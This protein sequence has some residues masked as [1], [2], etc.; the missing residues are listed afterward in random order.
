MSKSLFDDLKTIEESTVYGTQDNPVSHFSYLSPQ[1]TVSDLKGN[2][3]KSLKIINSFDGNTGLECMD[4][5]AL[6]SLSELFL[7]SWKMLRSPFEFVCLS[8][9]KEDSRVPISFVD[10]S[11]CTVETDLD[12]ALLRVTLPVLI[13]KK[14]SEWYKKNPQEF[15]FLDK[16][17]AYILSEKLKNKTLKLGFQQ[18]KKEPLFM[19]FRRHL[20]TQTSENTHCFLDNNNVECGVVTNT[21]C[22]SLDLT[23]GYQNMNFVYLTVPDEEDFFFEII[24]C[25]K[26]DL[27]SWI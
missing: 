7:K 9:K 6:L 2:V 23:D 26:A 12:T 14:R 27:S 4:L 25:Q 18:L 19:L 20:P 1:N 22:N 3:Q 17:I 16:E 5:R 21:I 13:G 8:E 10:D 11:I 15:Q 24:L